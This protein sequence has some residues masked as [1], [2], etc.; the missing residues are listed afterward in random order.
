MIASKYPDTSQWFLS[1]FWE[2]G[3]AWFGFSPD[4]LYFG[5]S[6]RQLSQAL[7]AML[8]HLLVDF[9]LGSEASQQLFPAILSRN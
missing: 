4:A 2:S 3:R 9:S 5:A 6:L 7:R 8:A 1:L